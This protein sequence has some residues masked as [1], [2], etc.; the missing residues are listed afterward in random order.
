MRLIP[1]T[2]LSPTVRAEIGKFTAALKQAET[3]AAASAGKG[4][5]YTAAMKEFHSAA[6]N[7]A[8][9]QYAA[10]LLLKSIGG[11]LT[12]GGLA[13]ISDFMRGK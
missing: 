1:R 12:L 7:T 11:G 10:Q 2:S 3:D 4:P 5:E 6:R 8:M 13:K 9:A